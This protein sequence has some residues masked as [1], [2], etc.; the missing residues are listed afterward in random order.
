MS[1]G[2]VLIVVV[3]LAVLAL[4]VAVWIVARKVRSNRLRSR[5]GPEY[6]KTVSRF[7][8]RRKAEDAREAHRNVS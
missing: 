6:D 8:D 3:A 5:F 4:V 7:G 2:T 1:Q